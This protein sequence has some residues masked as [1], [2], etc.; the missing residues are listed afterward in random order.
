[1]KGFQ[2]GLNPKYTFEQFV[3]AGQGQFKK[4]PPGWK[5]RVKKL[6]KDLIE[7]PQG[8]VATIMPDEFFNI[9]AKTGPGMSNYKP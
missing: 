7:R 8:G 1:M 2:V 5:F 9:Y 3:S 4:L 6:E